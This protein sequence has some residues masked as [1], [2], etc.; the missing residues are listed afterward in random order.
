M[1]ASHQISHQYV[2]RCAILGNIH[3]LT[4]QPALCL[5]SNV[6]SYLDE[7]T[8]ISRVTGQRA[9]MCDVRSGSVTVEPLRKLRDVGFPSMVSRH[10][11][12]T[13]LLHAPAQI[14]PFPDPIVPLSSAKNRWPKFTI[15]FEKTM[16]KCSGCDGDSWE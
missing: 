9:I 8:P 5:M 16:E 2:G 3:V 14:H 11:A 6:V 7:L 4:K 1:V 15:D 10:A 12:A 13:C